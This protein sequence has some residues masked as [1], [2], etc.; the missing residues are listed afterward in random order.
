MIASWM[1]RTDELMIAGILFMS[2]AA[3]AS[4]RP[5]DY[6][7]DIFVS[8]SSSDRNFVFEFPSK[9]FIPESGQLVLCVNM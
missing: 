8:P 7:G 2:A 4:E 3:V 9:I 6:L 1:S 5:S